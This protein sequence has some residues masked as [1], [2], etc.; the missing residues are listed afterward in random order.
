MY[1]RENGFRMVT[2]Y[3]KKNRKNGYTCTYNLLGNLEFCGECKDGKNFGR[4]RN[5]HENGVFA[6]SLN[7]DSDK[8]TGDYLGLNGESGK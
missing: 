2:S 3:F 6:C 4:G 5:Y 8:F 7:Y 1:H